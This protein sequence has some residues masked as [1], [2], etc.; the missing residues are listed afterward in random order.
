ME[1]AKT[2]YRLFVQ[3]DNKIF[4]PHIRQDYIA[5]ML[6]KEKILIHYIGDEIVGA[7][8]WLQ[9]KRQDPR[10]IGGRNDIQLKQIVVHSDYKKCGIGTILFQ[11]F[12]QF[13][14]ERGA[15]NICLSVRASNFKAQQFYLKMGMKVVGKYRMARKGTA[16]TRIN[17]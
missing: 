9:Y 15:P 8:V 14:Q 3:N 5:R 11:R 17:L 2:I 13:A 12:E 16:I 7:I 6:M 4:F 10:Q 1:K